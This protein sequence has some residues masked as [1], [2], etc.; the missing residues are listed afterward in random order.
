MTTATA[1]P[2]IPT[3]APDRTPQAQFPAPGAGFKKRHGFEG[4]SI[5]QK[6]MI[7]F[8][9]I[10]TLTVIIAAVGYFGIAKIGR[11]ID[12]G[13]QLALAGAL[14]SQLNTDVTQTQLHAE[15]FK[16]SD[17]ADELTQART[18]LK[19]ARQ[20]L[21]DASAV[22]EFNNEERVGRLGA[23]GGALESYDASLSELDA[24]RD[25]VAPAALARRGEELSRQTQFVKDSLDR[26]LATMR[27][28][29]GTFMYW[30]RLAI[31]ALLLVWVVNAAAVSHR[32]GREISGRV[33]AI[34][35]AMLRLVQGDKELVVPDLDRV[36]EFGEMARS[37][38]TFRRGYLKLDRLRA[39]QIEQQREKEE[40]R[41]QQAAML[42]QLADQFERTV[43]EVVG[44]VAS[45]S[46]Q[47]QLTAS[48]M[49]AAAAAVTPPEASLSAAARPGAASRSSLP[50]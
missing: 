29:V 30:T 35:A 19:R 1:Q 49:A 9:S 23:L 20:G 13:G 2:F 46:S 26:Q 25:R 21:I 12:E 27:N 34:T 45:A 14:T 11:D 42:L 47:L 32:I 6:L 18:F 8:T 43:G 38:E 33:K 39:E 16:A 22:P 44:S 37:L 41:A 17:S 24:D 5:V 31:V 7:C 4:M 50:K 36:D 10:L 28:E 40:M 15:R 48:S 3:P